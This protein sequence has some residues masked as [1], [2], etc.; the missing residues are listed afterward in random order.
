MSKLDTSPYKGVRDFYPEDQFIQNH[1]SG[2]WRKTLESFG[3]NEY[4][5]SILEPAE[6][7]KAKTGEEIVNEQT[8]TFVDRGE[9][10]VTLRPEMTPTVARMVAAR[11]RELGFPL[12]WYSIPNLFRYEAPQRGRLREHW[13]L[14]VDL[15]GMEGVEAEV[16]IVNI[17][18][19]IMRNFGAAD[20][21]FIIRLNSR[22]LV[23]KI[24]SLFDINDDN[25]QKV[26]KLLDKKA[27]ISEEEFAKGVREIVGENAD[28]FIELINSPDE[29]FEKIG[30]ESAEVKEIFAVSAALEALGVTNITF[31][32]TLM[33]GFDYYTGVVFEVF[34]THKDNPR[35]LFGGGRYNELLAL[36]GD[37][38]VA[39]FGFGAGDVTLKD[40][41]E[42]HQLLP[43]Y[44]SST[45]VYIATLSKE[46]YAEVEGVATR[47]RQGGVNVAV[48][49][50]GRKVG[51]QIKTADKQHIE[52]VMVVGEDEIGSGVYKIKNIRTGDELSVRL[53]E[54]NDVILPK[55]HK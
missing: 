10:T 51:D 39:A 32:Q 16:E 49:W 53:D 42:T 22:K 34:D 21:D 7:Y 5:A 4:G 45:H 36:F 14:N 26:S 37:E 12:R 35:S 11:R 3:Y 46:H 27:K 41:L 8:Y 18:Y 54:I 38:E 20:K 50:T 24:Y 13:Q 48:D 55:I 40:F 25:I 23:Q 31:N 2:V 1:I 17:A 44:S 6:L 29:I 9:R 19:R 43:A 30:K 52:F 15:F 28:A 33:R 47:L